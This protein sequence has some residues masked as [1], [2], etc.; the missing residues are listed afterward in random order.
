MRT[1]RERDIVEESR[2]P[3]VGRG[4]RPAKD[5][6]RQAT[7]RKLPRRRNQATV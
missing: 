4:L 7:C 3:I 5:P 1:M 6:T 2:R